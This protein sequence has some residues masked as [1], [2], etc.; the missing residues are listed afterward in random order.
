MKDECEQRTA[1]MGMKGA[2]IGEGTEIGKGTWIISDGIRMSPQPSQPSLL[3]LHRKMDI[4]EENDSVLHR[5]VA[6]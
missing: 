3:L 1:W 6:D 2:E 4:K 5:S